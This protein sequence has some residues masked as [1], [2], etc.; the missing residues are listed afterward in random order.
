MYKQELPLL[1]PDDEDLSKVSQSFR[2]PFEFLNMLNEEGLLNKDFKNQ[3]GNVSYQVACHQRVQN[4]GMLTKKI[5][6]LVPGTNVDAIERC[7]GHDGTYG[8]KSETHKIAMKI[9]RPIKKPKKQNL[10]V[11][12]V[13]VH[14]LHTI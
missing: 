6:E 14:L 4:F 3:L 11:L 2:D 1:F 13:T 8:V 5:L 7:S 9:A 10:I 12:L